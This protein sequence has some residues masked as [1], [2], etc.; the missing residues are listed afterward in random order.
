MTDLDYRM[1]GTRIR[2]YRRERGL[3]QEQLAED[4]EISAPFLSNVERAVKKAGLSVLL[5]IAEALGVPL[6][7]MLFGEREAGPADGDDDFQTLLQD[8]SVYE[9]RVL[10]EMAGAVKASLR[11][12]RNAA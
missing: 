3:T 10:L 8:C 9:R 7:V 5:R 6:D 12:N 11:K 4:A 1:I 2:A